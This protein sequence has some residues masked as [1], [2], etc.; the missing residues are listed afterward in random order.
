MCQDNLHD[1]RVLVL[2]LVRMVV[3]LLLLFAAL[4]LDVLLAVLAMYHNKLV[5]PYSLLCLAQERPYIILAKCSTCRGQ[6]ILVVE[7]I[8]K[9][10]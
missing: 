3:V 7:S 4:A 10:K 8:T 6:D 9:K 5:H 1:N 2:L